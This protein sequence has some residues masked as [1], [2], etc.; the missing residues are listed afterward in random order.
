MKTWL[1]GIVVFLL[2]SAGSTY[3]YVCHVKGL[4]WDAEATATDLAVIE[5]PAAV[6]PGDNSATAKDDDTAGNAAATDVP[7]TPED[8]LQPAPDL[9]SDAPSPAVSAGNL[10]DNLKSPYTVLFAFAGPQ[11]ENR[12]AF[13]AYLDALVAHLKAHPAQKVAL[14]GYT[15]DTAARENNLKLAQKRCNIIV[16]KLKER[17]LADRQMTTE[18]LG[19]ADPVA[20]NDTEAG[21]RL[22]RRVVITLV[23]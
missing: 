7:A 22:N 10:P 23:Q 15:D 11:P 9:K 14:R 20:T 18:A 21:R 19:E 2:W 12:T 16:D 4:C 3:W 13:E 8:T 17:G 1:I 5:P 6:M